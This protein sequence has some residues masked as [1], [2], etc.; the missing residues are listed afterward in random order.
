MAGFRYSQAI[1]LRFTVMLF[2]SNLDEKNNKQRAKG[3]E[4]RAKNNERG[5]SKK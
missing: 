5:R 1:L 4:Q 2:H 3:T